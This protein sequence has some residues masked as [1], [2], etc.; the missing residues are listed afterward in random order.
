MRSSNPALTRAFTTRQPDRS[1]AEILGPPSTASQGPIVSDG[2]GRSDRMTVGGVI[3]RTILLLALLVTAGAFGWSRVGVTDAAE[4]TLPSWTLLALFGTIGLIFL[5]LFK[6]H[7]A[8]FVAPAYALVAG[9]LVGAISHVYEVRFDGIVLQA[10]GL[11]VAVFFVMLALYTS[12]T[13][14]AT[15]RLVS[16]IIAATGGVMVFYLLNIVLGLVGFDVPFIHNSGPIGIAISGAIVVLAAFNFILDFAIIE[17]GVAAGA[18]A[19]REWFAAFGLLL[20]LVWLYVELLR[21]LSLL[22]S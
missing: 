12:R 9:A 6:P 8:R 14:R 10:A 5:N 2:A 7:L 1:V 16:G 17:N 20:T 3:G 13:I 22:R 21:L 11:T 18:P 15:P 19:E 4:T